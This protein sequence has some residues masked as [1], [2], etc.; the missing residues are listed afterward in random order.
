VQEGTVPALRHA[1][2]R[3]HHFFPFQEALMAE[4]EPQNAIQDDELSL[5]ELE[6][7]G[8]GGGDELVGDSPTIN[9]NGCAP[10]G[11]CNC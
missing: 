5:E 9:T 2:S 6:A 11:N 7:A 10:G 8:G 1:A 3:N 4:H